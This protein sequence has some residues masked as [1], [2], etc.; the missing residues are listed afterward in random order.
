MGLTAVQPRFGPWR[1]ELVAFAELFAVAGILIAQPTFDA[2]SSNLTLLVGLHIDTADA[3]LFTAVVLLVPAVVLWCVEVVVGLVIPRGRRFVHAAMIGILAGVLANDI[4][5]KSLGMDVRYLLVVVVI[6]A[7]AFLFLRWSVIGEWLRFLA[8]APLIFAVMFV[9]NLQPLLGADSA[10]A[11]VPV[12][13]VRP[14]RVV[15]VVFDELPLESLMDGSGHIDANA[16]PNFAALAGTSNWYRNTMTVA[17]HTRRAFPP[18]LTGQMPPVEGKAP[19]ASE[20]PQTL[21]ASLAPSHTMNV[22]EVMESLCP[23]SACPD[24]ASYATKSGLD[25]L[26]TIGW[27]AAVAFNRPNRSDPAAFWRFAQSP[28]LPK[29]NQFVASIKPSDGPVLDYAH[30]ML[31]HQPWRWLGPNAHDPGGRRRRRARPGGCTSSPSRPPTRWSV[32][33]S[34]GSGRSGRSMIPSSSSP[35]ITALPSPRATRTAT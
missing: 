24:P 11:S 34:S 19:V 7:A 8:I 4:F 30:L 5:K 6:G 2:I 16:F 27:R 26:L 3:L 22:H 32:G 9:F 31:P 20:Y 10:G 15:L 35:R 33:C 1:R 23:R 13:A 17:D 12:G 21:F 29:A 28:A 14:T 18:I 25:G